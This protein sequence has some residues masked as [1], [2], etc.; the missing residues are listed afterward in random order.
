MTLVGELSLWV[1][2]L[3]SVWSTVASFAGGALHR[4]DVAQSGFRGLYATFAMIAL[5]AAGLWTA[6]LSRDFSL[7]YVAAHISQNTPSVYVFTAF[8]NGPAGVT[9]FWALVISMCG[10]VAIGLS[11]LQ[12]RE[13]EPWVTGTLSAILLFLIAAT[14]FDA[15]PFARVDMTPL[16]GQGMDPRLQTPAVALHRPSLFIGYAATAVPFAFGVAALATRRLDQRW[17]ETARRWTLFSWLFLTI[18]ILFGM[19][20]A[21]LEP[22]RGN[23]WPLHS[24]ETSAILPWLVGAA[25]LHSM[26]AQSTRRSLRKWTVVSLQLTF[27]FSIFAAFMTRDALEDAAGTSGHSL[28]GTWFSAFFF[29]AAGITVY[30]TGTRL[31]DTEAAADLAGAIH[32]RSRYGGYVA[33]A[34]IVILLVALAGLS[35]GRKYD[36]TLKTGE[37][38]QATDPFGHVWR[39]V[40]QGVSQ[41]DR[42]DYV[43]AILALDA[44]RDGKRLGLLTSERRTFRDIQGNQLFEPSTLVGMHSTAL[45]DTYVVPADLRRERGSDIAR[46]HVEFNPLVMWVWV[47]GIV[48]ILGGVVALWPR[49]ETKRA[50]TELAAA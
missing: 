43:V 38:Y 31:R 13:L 2:L 9:L 48:M 12:N 7:E 37:S 49:A 47:G 3:L 21:Y 50:A 17:L 33:H 5:A 18:G 14:C 23:A 1:A 34:G 8:W 39:F 45:L 20:W 11:R 24:V 26:I 10:S 32:Q 16:D 30:L 35:F 40:S 22:D 29:M 19:R 36:T 28:I 44:Y 4:S 46:V 41:F 6:L 27:L 42:A 25:S 15:N